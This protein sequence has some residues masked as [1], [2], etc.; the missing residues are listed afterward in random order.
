MPEAGSVG[1]QRNEG[2]KMSAAT[3]DGLW[4]TIAALRAELEAAKRETRSLYD[5]IERVRELETELETARAL[6]NGAYS[7]METARSVAFE[8]AAL[9]VPKHCS[10]AMTC[11]CHVT[12]AAI[13]ALAPLTGDMGTSPTPTNS[14]EGVW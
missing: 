14:A 7:D 2:G 13:R 11:Q 8:E 4:A 3:I 5:A 10:C 9:E 1:R 6:L 12:Q